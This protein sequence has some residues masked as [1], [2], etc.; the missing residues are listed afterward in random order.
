[1]PIERRTR[2]VS[3]ARMRRLGRALLDESVLCTIATVSPRGS[4]HVNTA[5]FARTHALEIIWISDPA[6]AHSRYLHI[7]STAAL[8][9][10]DSHQA[11]GGHDRGIQLFGLAAEVDER[12]LSEAERVYARRFH[13]FSPS[14]FPGYR[15]YRF[16]PRRVKLFDEYILGAG[17]FVT[18]RVRSG[19][20]LDWERTDVYRGSV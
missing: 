5:Y 6:A 9:V 19:G 2:P 14:D 10:Y 17:V 1:M 13:R 7:A 12:G 16:V 3:E 18:A 4:A 20:H 8:A 15:F 11:W